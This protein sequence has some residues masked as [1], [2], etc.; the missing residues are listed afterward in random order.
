MELN[1]PLPTIPGSSQSLYYRQH[2]RCN[3]K[4]CAKSK[5]MMLRAVEWA[6][7]TRCRIGQRHSCSDELIGREKQL[8]VIKER[9][10]LLVALLAIAG[11]TECGTDHVGH[12]AYVTLASANQIAGDKIASSGKLSQIQGSPFSAG[13]SPDSI[14]I[15]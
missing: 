12:V 13:S 1:N 7:Q 9:F 5:P 14:Y 6:E 10:F 15:Q 4:F 2:L 3:A 11:L 8:D